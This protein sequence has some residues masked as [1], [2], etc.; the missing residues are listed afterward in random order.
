MID[1]LDKGGTQISIREKP[2][3]WRW[4]KRPGIKR[5]QPK[6]D[7]DSNSADAI[8]EA[9]GERACQL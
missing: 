2:E 3:G 7:S 9:L 6:T 1:Q 5:N 8:R 4:N